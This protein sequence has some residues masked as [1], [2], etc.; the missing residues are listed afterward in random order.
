MSGARIGVSHLS[1]SW[2][3]GTPVVSDLSFDL[4]GSRIGLVA[5]N[6]AGKS[7]LLKLLAGELQPS[8]GAIRLQGAVGY[9]PQDLVLDGA[10]SVVDALGVAAK[11]RALDAILAGEAGTAEFDLVD[12]DWNL[13]ERIAAT[14]ARL[15]LGEVSLQRRLST[16]SGGEAMSLA[17]AAK[18]LQRP[19]VLLLDEPSN[20]LD[21]AARHRL[22]DALAQWPGCVLVASHDRELLEGMEQIA[23]L[24][25]SS[26]RLYG[27]GFGFYRQAVEA[28]R[29]AAEQRVRHLRGEVRR[30][31]REMQQAR[32]RAERRAGTA[33]RNLA[34][35]GLA[36]IVAGNRERAAQVSAGKAGDVH[37]RRLAQ[38][39]ARLLDAKR[40][41]DSND[42]PDL[43]LPATCVPP[44]RLLV[45]CEGIRVPHGPHALFGE[46]GVS[47]SIRGP[48]R[49]ALLGGNGTGKTTLL[50]ILAGEPIPF[51]GALRR[52]QGRSAYLSQRLELLDPMRSVA[53]NFAESA[54]RM[55]AHERADLLARLQFR[56]ARMQ[57]PAGTLSG[58]ERVR[59]VLACVLHADPAPQL[60][61]L[62][63]PTNN[64]DLGAIG[65]LEQALRAYEGAMVVVS[66]DEAFLDAIG[67][68]R[69]LMLSHAGIREVV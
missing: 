13:R 35:A 65:Q 64:L 27:G 68:T 5:P 54:P 15:G 39:R 66:H 33:S 50:R 14:L 38:T 9:L 22:R 42:L 44:D 28:E 24:G 62:D 32:E 61:L 2:P 25:P 6:G 43:S 10:A 60:L 41:V 23:E 18:L 40:S 8:S 52:G 67:T 63:E 21:R 11:L 12:G 46:S 58:G 34:D 56:G 37:A 7:T 59:A 45:A 69:R 30:E 48:E 16:F 3:D 53:E 17:L 57:L 31:Q 1:F 20:H 49:L 29:Q 51:E 47:L 36:R 4:G 55:P 19:D 26:L